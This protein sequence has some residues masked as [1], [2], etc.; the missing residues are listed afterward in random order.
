VIH[1]GLKGKKKWILQ[2]QIL[3]GFLLIKAGEKI[4]T[5]FVYGL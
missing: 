1:V 4:S 3:H 5:E 2:K